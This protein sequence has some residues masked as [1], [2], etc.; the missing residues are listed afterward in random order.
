VYQEDT[1]NL[2]TKLFICTWC[3]CAY[4]EELTKRRRWKKERKKGER[5]KE[6]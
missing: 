6:R 5:E 2:W 4:E 3:S 1:D